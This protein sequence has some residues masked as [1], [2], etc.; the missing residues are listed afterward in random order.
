MAK[1]AARSS[2]S[3]E[4][5]DCAHGAKARCI[6]GPIR[7]ARVRRASKTGTQADG[8]RDTERT[9]RATTQDATSADLLNF[10]WIYSLELS[11][12]LVTIAGIISELENIDVRHT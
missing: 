6:G 5:A 2:G 1:T 10:F 7:A 4:D 12:L 11:P 9:T 8:R 3:K